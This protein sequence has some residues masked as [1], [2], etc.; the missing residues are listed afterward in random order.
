MPRSFHKQVNRLSAA[1]YPVPLQISVAE[2]V[3]RNLNGCD[4]IANKSSERKKVAVLPYVHTVSHNLKK[5]AQKADVRVVF[6]A[7]NKLNKLC[8]LT[9]PYSSVKQLC[10][11]KHQTAYVDC[12]DCVVYCIPLSCGKK[13]VGQTGC[14]LNDRLRQHN[15]NVK[16][17]F[18]SNLAIHCSK[19]RNCAP[20][21]NQC[22]II[23]RSRDQLTREIIEAQNIASLGSTCV[24]SPSISL[25]KK[26][27]AFLRVST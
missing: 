17:S 11:I 22:H 25:S 4:E 2:R 9:K 23:G 16:N 6:T 1:G 8:K 12:V 26:E 24:S 27:L 21:L 20:L 13:Y 15:N 18:G 3:L 10:G 5:V 7:P 14:C 19:C